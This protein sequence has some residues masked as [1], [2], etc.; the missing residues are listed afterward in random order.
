M[1]KEFQDFQ[2]LAAK[3]ILMRSM[4]VSISNLQDMTHPASKCF[5]HKWSR[6]S[7]KV[8]R[9]FSTKVVVIWAVCCI[10]QINIYEVCSQQ[11]KPRETLYK[12]LGT[13]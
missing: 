1:Y 7:N 4:Y 11:I 10:S 8:I 13:G 2:Y 6:S 5:L 9:N 3:A 12:E